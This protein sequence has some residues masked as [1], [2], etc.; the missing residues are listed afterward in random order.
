MESGDGLIYGSTYPDPAYKPLPLLYMGCLMVWSVSAFSWTFNTWRKR[1]FQTNNLQ[2]ML[3]LVPSIK[4]VQLG[5]SCLF[6]YS[7]FSFQ[8]CSLWVSFGVY[9]T[10]V[11]FQITCLVSFLLISHGYSIMCERLSVS[12][13]RTTAT[14]ACV[15][16]LTLV[17]YKAALPYFSVLLLLNHIV[18][19]YVIFL[20]IY[21]NL[22]ALREQLN[23]IEQENMP[24]TRE[25][26]YMKYKMFKN[27]QDAMKIAALVEILIYINTGGA[28]DNYWIRLLIREWSQ[29][30]IFF[31][32]GWIFRSQEVSPGFHVVPTVNSKGRKTIPTIYSIEMDEADFSNL[33]FHEWQIGVPASSAAADNSSCKS[34]LI[35]VKNPGASTKGISGNIAASTKGN[36]GTLASSRL[37]S[38]SCTNFYT[39]GGTDDV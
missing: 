5:L 16:Y 20:H 34:H 9:I 2:W 12:E 19:Y 25:A 23:Y 6:W 29:F 7:C 17:G 4:A 15:L 31:Y 37:T 21:Q 24:A 27:F 35:V 13:H 22:L 33:D 32:V 39:Q 36:L 3:T 8:T 14:M 28:T 26:V 11:F 18:S 10:G 30:C 1:R 38:V